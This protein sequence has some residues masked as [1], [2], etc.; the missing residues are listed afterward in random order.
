MFLVFLTAQWRL[1]HTGSPG[2]AR[3]FHYDLNRRTRACLLC[4]FVPLPT[5]PLQY[6]VNSGYFLWVVHIFSLHDWLF[7]FMLQVT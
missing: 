1:R 7:A 6:Y 2:L 3:V 4:I 5:V